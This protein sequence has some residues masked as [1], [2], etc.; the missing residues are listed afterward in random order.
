MESKAVS[1]FI[2]KVF[3]RK[4]SKLDSKLIAKINNATTNIANKIAT[5]FWRFSFTFFESDFG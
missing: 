4:L 1:G 2:P 5:I 3:T